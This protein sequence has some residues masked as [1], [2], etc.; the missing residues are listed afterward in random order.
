MAKDNKN[1]V[2][3][4]LFIAVGGTALSVAAVFMAQPFIKKVGDKLYKHSL[5]KDDIDYENNG[6]VI[7][8]KIATQSN[9]KN[10]SI[11]WG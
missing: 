9:D 2:V 11:A 3:K 4:N 5:K 8:T 6:P 1:S 10:D 7:V